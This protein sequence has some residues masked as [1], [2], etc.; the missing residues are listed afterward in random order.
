MGKDTAIEWATHTFNPWIGCTKIAPEC[1]RCYAH[2]ETFVRVQRSRGRELWGPT[3]DRHVTS[4]GNWR[5]VLAWNRMAH[6]EGTRGR[7]FC[8]SLADVAEDRPDLVEP[9]ARLCDLIR[10]TDALDWLLLTKRLE[11]LVRL[12]PADV[13]QRAWVGTTAGT[14]DRMREEAP[15]LAEI[16]CRVRFISVEPMLEDVA[17]DLRDALVAIG[18]HVPR[19]VVAGGESAKPGDKPARPMH[20]DWTRGVRNV[21]VS[22][23][24]PFLFKQWGDWQDGSVIEPGKPP[25]GEIVLLDGRHGKTPEDLGF[26]G[27][28]RAMEWGRLRPTMMARVGKKAAGRMLDGREW[29]EF[30]TVEATV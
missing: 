2:D 21:C 27:I 23:G 29:N 14:V 22:L 15:R 7:V 13:L 26:T 3:A 12:F 16:D 19:W 10:R 11:D 30:P 8:A 28:A 6:A 20:P 24:V 4:A 5:A 1:A 18:D 25:V 17:A 9:R